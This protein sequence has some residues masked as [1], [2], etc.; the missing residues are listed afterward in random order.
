MKKNKFPVIFLLSFLLGIGVCPAN[1]Q[2][3]A[4]WAANVGWDG[5]AHW[6]TYIISMPRYLGPNAL[7]VPELSK[8]Q[9]AERSSLGWEGQVHF[10]KG[11]HTWNAVLRGVYSIAPGK[12]SVEALWIPVEYAVVSHA[13]KTERRIFHLFYNQRWATG[14]VYIQTNLQLLQATPNKPGLMLRMGQRLPASNMQGAARFTDA[15]GFYLDLSTGIPLSGAWR[16]SLMSG[17]FIWQTN[18]DDQFQNDAFLFG[19]GATRSFG[20]WGLDLGFRGYLGYMGKGDDPLAANARVSY[21][22]K[23]WQWQMGFQQGFLDLRY[24]SFQTGVVKLLPL[25]HYSMQRAN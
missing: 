13:L 1:A 20:P 22:R 6:S 3:H 24:V 10:M 21:A 18:R 25:R 7:P 9:V 23:G 5:K 11:D 16:L 14:D 8:G 12:V 15:P 2:D 4:W 17:V 19:L